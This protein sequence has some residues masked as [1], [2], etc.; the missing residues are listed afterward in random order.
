MGRGV[1]KVLTKK[2]KEIAAKN[3]VTSYMIFMSSIM[4]LLSKYSRQE[5]IVIGTPISGRTHR[6]TEDMLGMFVNT[7]ALLSFR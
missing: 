7:L 3:E 6:D 2:I 4:I 5:D 1:G